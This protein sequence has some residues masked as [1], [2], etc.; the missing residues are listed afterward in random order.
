MAPKKAS[1]AAKTGTKTLTQKPASKGAP[2][3]TKSPGKKVVATAVSK[4]GANGSKT[5]PT[6]KTSTSP[7]KGKA[8]GKENIAA[9]QVDLHHLNMPFPSSREFFKTS[10]KGNLLFW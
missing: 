1:L 10:L 3:P 9:N 5:A 6:K 2:S 7:T 8:K 4:K